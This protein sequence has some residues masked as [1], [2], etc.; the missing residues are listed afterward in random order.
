VTRAISNVHPST[1]MWLLGWQASLL[2]PYF[3]AIRGGL[4][5]MKNRIEPAQWTGRH[6]VDVLGRT[7]RSIAT[8]RASSEGRRAVASDFDFTERPRRRSPKPAGRADAVVE[9]QQ[10]RWAR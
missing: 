8:T 1:G 7:P 2:H 3:W 10:R 4:G 5:V 9:C 6:P